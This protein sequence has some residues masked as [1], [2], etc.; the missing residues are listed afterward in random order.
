[1]SI[2]VEEFLN[3]VGNAEGRDK[4]GKFIQFLARWYSDVARKVFDNVELGQQCENFWRAMLDG[5]RLQWFGKS[6]AEWKTVRA[7]L[8][9]KGLSPEVRTLHALARFG[10]CLRWAVENVM[11]L[12]K[13]KVLT[14]VKWQ[15]LNKK[16][17][18][19][20][21]ASIICGILSECCKFSQACTKDDDAAK[22]KAAV[23]T[24]CHI[25]D[26]GV[27]LAIG[28]DVALSDGVIGFG[29]MVAASIQSYN[30]FQ[31]TRSKKK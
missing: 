7:T 1:M 12:Y 13:L 22:K 29:H 23:T 26:M 16:A 14:G 5:R 18:R 4:F 30:I 8:D 10:F 15:D 25:G 3:F 11:I 20:W 27:P 24:I 6:L 2:V 21:M 31:N 17:K 28:F 19:I 9:N